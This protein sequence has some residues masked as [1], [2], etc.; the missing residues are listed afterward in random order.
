MASQQQVRQY[1]AYWFQLGKKVLIR[2]GEEYLLP[3]PIIEGNRYSRQFEECWKI[4]NSPE[5][6]DCYLDGTHETIAQLLTS[7]WDVEN[8][9]R[10][11]MPVPQKNRGLPSLCCPCFDLPYWPDNELPLPRAPIDSQIHLNLIQDRLLKLKKNLEEDLDGEHEHEAPK[12]L[13]IGCLKHNCRN[14]CQMAHNHEPV[15][16]NN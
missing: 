9:A 12:I 11:T 13:G 14:N 6:G 2:N 16:I 1:L 8:C 10:C 5:A 3:K 4:I 15:T 7:E